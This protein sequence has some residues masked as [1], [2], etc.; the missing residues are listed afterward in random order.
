MVELPPPGYNFR[1]VI[2]VAG[3]GVETLLDGGAAMSVIIEELLVDIINGA[4]HRGL[5][6]ADA[7]WPLAGLEW[8]GSDSFACSVSKDAPLRILGIVLLRTTLRG[9]DGRERVARHHSRRAGA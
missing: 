2:Y 9:I 6:P 8:W 1:T 7:A 5:S 4:L 3:K